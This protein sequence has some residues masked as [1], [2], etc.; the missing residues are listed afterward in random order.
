MCVCVWAV[1]G[2]YIFLFNKTWSLRKFC[3]CSF[4]FECV[5]SLERLCKE[6]AGNAG[7]NVLLSIRIFVEKH[8]R[9]ALKL[10]FVFFFCVCVMLAA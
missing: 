4:E 1:V 9:L 6:D 2:V 10:R 3:I 8:I 7:Y 5:K